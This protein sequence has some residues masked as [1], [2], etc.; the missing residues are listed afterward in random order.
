MYRQGISIFNNSNLDLSDSKYN[1]NKELNNDY[2]HTIAQK[3]VGILNG[4]E[5]CIFSNSDLDLDLSDSNYDPK[6]DLTVAI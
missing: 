3:S 5:I 6:Q 2:Q 4:I 1:P